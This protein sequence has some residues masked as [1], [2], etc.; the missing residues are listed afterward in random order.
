MGGATGSG[1]P[2]CARAAHGASAP[3][4]GSATSPSANTK[5]D[6]RTRARLRDA[7]RA[8]AMELCGQ[9]SLDLA[10]DGLL[11]KCA[12]QRLDDLAV[13]EQVEARDAAD[14]VLAR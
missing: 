10:Q 4:T 2:A 9:V 11:R 7:T 13:L 14:P 1:W 8:S 12:N 3:D 5:A 6:P